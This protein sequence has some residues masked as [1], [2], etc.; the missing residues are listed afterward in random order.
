VNDDVDV[1]GIVGFGSAVTAD[2]DGTLCGAPAGSVV[3]VVVDVE[4]VVVSAV[5]VD[6]A[7]AAFRAAAS[8]ANCD[9]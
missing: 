9:T 5:V 7:A 4:V 2:S 8:A 6:V 1:N 3:D